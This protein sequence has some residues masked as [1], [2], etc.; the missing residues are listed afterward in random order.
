MMSNKLKLNDD[1]THLMVMTTS[2][3]RRTNAD[4][5]SIAIRTPSKCI[6]QSSSEKLLGGWIHQNMKWDEHLRDSKDCLTKSLNKRLGALRK[7][8][9]SASFKQRKSIADGI[10]LSKL[11]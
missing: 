7:I 10:V 3:H 9:K 6:E 5:N 8:Y 4:V 1:K 11:T 2:S